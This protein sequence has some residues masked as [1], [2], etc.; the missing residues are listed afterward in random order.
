MEKL[1]KVSGIVVEGH[2]VASGRSTTSPY[3]GGS[4]I[5]QLPHFNKLG[6][7]LGGYFLGTINID[8]S[9]KAMELVA[10]DYEARQIRWTDLIP[11][12]DFFF[13]RCLIEYGTLPIDA[14][15]YHPS[16]ETKV[17]NFH[18]PS[19]IEVLAP[20]LE[21]LMVGDK[22]KLGLNPVHYSLT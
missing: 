19:I 13:S 22:I 17:E 15:V 12:E 21:G 5:R 4:L 14:M 9:P 18:N 10:W 8:I 7:P 20:N 11:P 16:P 2:G 3:P 1:V 6:I